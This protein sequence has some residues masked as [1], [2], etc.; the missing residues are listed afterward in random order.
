MKKL[1]GSVS[2]AMVLGCALALAHANDDINTSNNGTSDMSDPSGVVHQ[3]AGTAADSNM[4]SDTSG[5]PNNMKSETTTTTTTSKSAMNKK[6]CTDE[7]GKVLTH[8][9]SGYRACMKAHK[10]AQMGG[11]ADDSVNKV[12]NQLDTNHVDN[13]MNDTTRGNQ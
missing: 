10:K 3:E 12:G 7:N 13:G 5:S 1:I 2:V 9:Q 6:S 8:G 4:N 11:I